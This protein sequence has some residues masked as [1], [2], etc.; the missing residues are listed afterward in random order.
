MGGALEMLSTIQKIEETIEK[1]QHEIQ[2]KQRIIKNLNQS[3]VDL[4]VSYN[5]CLE[6]SGKGETY[7]PCNDGDPYHR[8]SDDWTVCLKCKGSGKITK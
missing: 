1:L 2:E 3:K 8:S 5:I 7:K 4:S 6:C